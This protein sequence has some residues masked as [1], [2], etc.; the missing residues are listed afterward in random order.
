M[1]GDAMVQRRL[2]LLL[3]VALGCAASW[4]TVAEAD[5]WSLHARQDPELDVEAWSVGIE[6][7]RRAV[8]DWLGP[9]E[10]SVK[11]HVLEGP[12]H[13]GED[14]R[15]VVHAAE[16]SQTVAGVGPTTVRGYH[17]REAG[18]SGIYVRTAEPS[19]LVHELVHARMEELGAEVPLWFEEGVASLLADG[20]L[21]EGYWVRDGFC[22]WPW[23]RLRAHRPSGLE[24]EALLTRTSSTA[25]SVR[26][27]VLAHLLGWALVFDL[28]RESQSDDWRDWYEEFDWNDPL[29]DAQRRLTRV[30]SP[31]VPAAWLRARLASPQKGV[32][33]ASLKGSWKVLGPSTAATLAAALETET[34]AEV[35]AALAI[36]LL[37]AGEALGPDE[38]RLHA[39][40]LA[41]TALSEVRLADPVEAAAARDL[42][43]AVEGGLRDS[44]RA[45]EG[46][47]RFWEE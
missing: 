16:A 20:M 44:D 17:A 45:L 24:L 19:T 46:L 27:N 40:T 8:E 22:A 26:E 23:A 5:G 18:A 12:V 4:H 35:R 21:V 6:P 14:G 37:A 42:V 9:F 31:E 1:I 30:L 33:L 43:L 2:P 11:V 36:N 28:W 39:S 3:L 41:V 47:R 32:R 13:L 15:S 29:R 38:V 25:E 10:D 7:S 34:D